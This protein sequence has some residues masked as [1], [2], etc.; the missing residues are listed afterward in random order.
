MKRFQ[1]SKIIGPFGLLNK[2]SENFLLP[3][4]A[5]KIKREGGVHRLEKYDCRDALR[6]GAVEQ[7]QFMSGSL[8]ETT[9]LGKLGYKSIY[10][11]F[12]DVPESRVW[13]A[14]KNRT[15]CRMH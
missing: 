4:S 14:S 9:S 6:S 10:D 7:H 13:F 2:Y 5:D 1:I 8:E 11:S 15:P 12:S 3:E